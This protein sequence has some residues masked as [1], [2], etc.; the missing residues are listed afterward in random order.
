MCNK[1]GRDEDGWRGECAIRQGEMR[2]D[3]E[4]SV[5]EDN[6]RKFSD[7][8]MKRWERECGCG[9]KVFEKDRRKKYG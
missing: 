1:T 5:Q 8:G 9:V 6:E 4:V 3:G 2:M 7:R